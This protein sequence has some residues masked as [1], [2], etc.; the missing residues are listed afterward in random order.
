MPKVGGNGPSWVP[1]WSKGLP[2]EPMTFGRFASGQSCTGGARIIDDSILEVVGV[3]CGV[4]SWIEDLTQR[5]GHGTWDYWRRVS[6]EVLR[7]DE[8]FGDPSDPQL[9]DFVAT[10]C[11]N[12]VR[13]MYPSH[14]YWPTVS[15]CKRSLESAGGGGLR[16]SETGFDA[17]QNSVQDFT[18]GRRF[19][20]GQ[21]FVGFGAQSIAEGDVIA[22]LLGFDAP[23]VLRPKAGGTM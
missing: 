14:I 11:G 13:E 16:R 6:K 10:L 5:E 4:I 8:K 3:E 12:R 18:H 19:F 1:D 2:R 20:Q 15:Q 22:V 7:F 17:F 21:G 9:D 23:V